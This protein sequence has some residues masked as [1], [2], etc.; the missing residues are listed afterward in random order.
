MVKLW[1][2][3]GPALFLFVLLFTWP[4]HDALFQLS[5]WPLALI[6]SMGLVFSIPMYAPSPGSIS[7]P[8]RHYSQKDGSL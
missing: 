8:D 6:Y 2:F 3:K 7:P 1:M 4:I 5:G